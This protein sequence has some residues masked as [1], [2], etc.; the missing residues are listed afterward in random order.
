[1][2]DPEKSAYILIRRRL[3]VSRAELAR[4]LGI[5]RPTASSVCESLLE[6]KLILECGKGKAARGIAPTLLSANKNLPG[7]IGID[8][9]YTDKM[10]AVLIDGAGDIIAQQEMTF[11][12]SDM[13]SIAGSAEKI[14]AQFSCNH[15]V[16]GVAL[17]L[18]AVIDE[19]SRQVLKSVNPLFCSGNFVSVLEAELGQPVF[20]SNRS[21]AAA[22]SEAFGGAADREKD[23]ALIS[24]GKSVGAAFW[25]GGELFCGSNSSAGEIRNLRLTD[26]ERLEEALSRERVSACSREKIVKKCAE[27]LGQ[28]IDI[29]DFKLF[30]LSGRFA[31]FGNDFAPQL[32][33][34]LEAWQVKVKQAKFG[35]FSAARG[36][37][38]QMVEELIKGE[39][40]DHESRNIYSFF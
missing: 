1:M 6:K 35:R 40:K 34:E 39:K 22:I 33:K 24:L 30:V 5:S 32:E 26:G 14:V 29:M 28:I 38:F 25:C 10:S 15:A 27:A 18:S 16:S 7:V 31:D 3:A 17:A 19:K 20:I 21:R 8:F 23:F 13:K 11:N 12:P 37:A 36:S 2:T 4:S 9:G